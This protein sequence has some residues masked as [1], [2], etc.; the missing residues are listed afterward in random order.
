MNYNHR[1]AIHGHRGIARDTHMGDMSWVI[2]QQQM[3]IAYAEDDAQRAIFWRRMEYLY[4]NP[5]QPAFT[6]AMWNGMYVQ[7]EHWLPTIQRLMDEFPDCPLLHRAIRTIMRNA[8]PG[9]KNWRTH[10]RVL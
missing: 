1:V 5:R 9:F 3:G 2:S 6:P 8:R 4:T 10:N 7:L